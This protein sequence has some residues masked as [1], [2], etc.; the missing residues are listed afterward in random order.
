MKYTAV[1]ILALFC[2]CVNEQQRLQLQLDEEFGEYVEV[3]KPEDVALYTA[4]N[5]A[6]KLWKTPFHEVNIKTSFGNAHVIVSGAKDAEPLV[7]LH[8]MNASSTMWYP[9]VKALSKNYRV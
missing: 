3:V 2:S 1:I 5:K 9:N 7:L 4:Y 6:L 8:G